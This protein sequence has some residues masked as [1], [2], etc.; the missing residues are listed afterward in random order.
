[1]AK[2]G[3]DSMQSRQAYRGE[4][5]TRQLTRVLLSRPEHFSIA[6][7]VNPFSSHSAPVD[8]PL[9][10]TQ[11]DQLCTAFQRVGLDISLVDPCPG[12]EDMC[13]AAMQSFVGVDH[14]ERSFVV[15]SRMLHRHRRDEVE[16]FSRWYS[17]QGYRILELDLAGEEFLEG[18]GDLLWNPDW[19]S[20][21]AGFGHR[22]TR[23]AVDQFAA[24]MEE[25]G[26]GVRKLELVDPH[27]FHLNLCLAP[28]APDALL[29]YPGAFAPETLA[30]IRLLAHT[31]EITREEALQFVC[32][33][34]S[35]NG[36]YITPRLTRRLEQILGREGIEPIVVELSE[37]QK[38]GAS[39]ASLKMLLP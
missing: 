10:L 29:I 18:G 34:V 4:T 2:T 24:L 19:E 8:L 27:F 32:N 38:A 5:L 33:G 37:F 39:I 12:L 26:F 15:P 11:W 22:S 6:E 16:H 17:K 35:V 36:Y 3:T 23:A 31:Y 21:W 13:F 20:I 7:T 9:A 25:M 14:D 30:R 28:L 1:M